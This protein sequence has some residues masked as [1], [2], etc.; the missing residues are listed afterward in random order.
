MLGHANIADQHVGAELPDYSRASAAEAAH[1]HLGPAIGE[2]AADELAGVRLV[3]DDEHPE[4]GERPLRAIEVAGP[5]FLRPDLF[6]LGRS[7]WTTV[8]GSVTVKVAPWPSPG[9]L[10]RTLP[11][12]ISTSCL[13][14][15]RP[16]PQP[17]V[18]PGRRSV[19]LAEAVEDVRQEFGP[20][21]DAGVDDADL[22][23]RVDP[24]QEHL[25]A[26]P[27]GRELDG[28]RE[29]VP[30]DLLEPCGIAGD[31]T[32][33]RIEHLLNADLLGIG[34]REHGGEGGFDDLG[35]VQ[36]LDVEPQVPRDDAGDVE[37]VLDDLGLGLGIP[38][39]GREALRQ[40]LWAIQPERRILAQPT[41]ALSGVRSS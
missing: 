2:D 17:A 13:T 8:M 14:M 11:P 18:P 12:C 31:R 40:V 23:V 5:L 16:E 30:D 36:P 26:A 24:L 19:G 39:D 41:M 10:A 35:K 6:R 33:E 3:I 28:V 9:L 29:E 7:G 22:D 20:D 21:A 34:G 1:G 4:A 38:V 25:D 32:C 27:L 37:Q 15:A